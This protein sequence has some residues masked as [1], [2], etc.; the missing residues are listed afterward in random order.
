MG[1]VFRRF[2]FAVFWYILMMFSIQEI[3]FLT[4][5]AITAILAAGLTM[6]VNP[7]LKGAEKITEVIAPAEAA[8]L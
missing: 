1:G 3:G 7:P 2:G 5:L 6:I 4:A 8:G